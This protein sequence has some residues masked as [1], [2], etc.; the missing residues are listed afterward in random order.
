MP[1]GKSIIVVGGSKGGVGKSLV[2]MAVIDWLAEG[3]QQR[4]VVL[5][6]DNSNPDVAKVCQA[7][8]PKPRLLDLDSQDGWLNLSDRCSDHADAHVVVNT[9]A[10]SLRALQQFSGPVLE[11]IHRHLGRPTVVLWVIN[12]QRDSVELLRQYL[13]SVQGPQAWPGW[14]RLHVV[15]NAGEVEGRSFAFYEKTTTAKAVTQAGG[16][17]LRVSMLA[18]RVTTLLYTNR[19]PIAEIAAAAGSAQVS[20]SARIEMERWR[21]EMRDQL[22]K[23][24]LTGT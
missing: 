14:L 1:A 7:M 3:K 9:G 11:G 5:D 23:L 12:D 4:V 17:V 21:R 20:F 10:R 24:G 8:E 16:A 15:C 13:E 6:G 19:L 18:K 22:E 2:A